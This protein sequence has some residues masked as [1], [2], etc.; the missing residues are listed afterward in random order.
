MTDELDA[1]AARRSGALATKPLPTLIAIALG[2]LTPFAFA[3]FYWF[4]ISILTFAGFALVW[5]RAPS[6]RQ[7]LWTG[8]AFG[9]S[10]SCVGVSW[11][12]VSLH[13]FGGMPLALAMFVTF[14]LCAFFAIFPALAA[15]TAH[16]L[17]THS[18]S[19]FLFVLP[20]CWAL[21]EWLRGW[22]FTGF[23]WLAIGYSQV[24]GSPLSG[25]APVLGVLGVSLTTAG[26]AGACAIV[27]LAL[28]SRPARGG[29]VAA[30]AWLLLVLGIGETLK[31][32]TWTARLEPA[33][34][35][36]LL[37]GNIAQD[38]KWRPETAV[39]TLDVYERLALSSTAKL[40]I[41]PETA[42]PL[43]LD[44]APRDYLEGLRDHARRNGGDILIGVPESTGPR[45]Y[46]NSVVTLGTSPSQTYR[47]V[48]LVPFSEFIP[49][50]WL[51]GWVYDDLLN[52]PLAD[53]TAGTLDQPPLAAAGQKLAVTNCY[54]D[55][56]GEEVIRRLPQATMLVNVSNDAWFG[57]SL[58]PQQ[59]LQISQM[60]AA[61]TGRWMLRATN[62]GVTAIID[63]RGRVLSRA[64][65]FSATALDGH[66]QGFAGA[67]P[68][69]RWGNNAVLA[70]A[71]L[72][73]AASVSAARMRQPR[74]RGF[75]RHA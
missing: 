1:A 33:V 70:V 23:P 44:E 15:L 49:F 20:A 74:R 66:A 28:F 56:F 31:R 30:L 26:A 62:T 13:D 24:P 22:I 58:G 63:E 61:E 60:R 46:Y 17:K 40:I 71:V 36:S 52:M 34:S 42:L 43:F 7:A 68:Y 5:A 25:W 47:K 4:W 64:P 2:A 19:D 35:V 45:I 59:H 38:I 3:P 54:E 51:I 21:T 9:L 18:A 12:Y 57:R 29:A 37:Q 11:V 10:Q 8:L 75:D 41:M 55:L 14:L 27:A 50:K 67:T 65:E 6:A 32:H 39:G 53:F 69:V 73:I 72:M 48:H 16:L